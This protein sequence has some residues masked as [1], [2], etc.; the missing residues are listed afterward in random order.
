MKWNT[1]LYDNNHAFVSR[2]GEDVIALLNPQAGE[3]ILDLGCGTGD[4]AEIIRQKGAAVTGLDSSPEMVATAAGKYPHIRFDV[5]S[6]TDFSY[7][8]KFDAIFSNATLHWVLECQKAIAC[9]YNNLKPNGGRF[10]AEFGGKG[11]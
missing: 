2:Y 5:T 11:N 8:E 4:L 7:E 1:D 3:R 9:I 10:V 6:A